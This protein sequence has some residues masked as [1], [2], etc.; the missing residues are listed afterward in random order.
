MKENNYKKN[1]WEINNFLMDKKCFCF[2]RTISESVPLT[3]NA[4]NQTLRQMR[5]RKE[6]RFH[7]RRW[8][9]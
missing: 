9:I 5:K 3:K 1:R 8:G 7:R 4:V 2:K 6:I